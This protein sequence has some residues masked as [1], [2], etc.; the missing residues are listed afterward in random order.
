[1]LARTDAFAARVPALRGATLAVAVLRPD[2]GRVT[3]T[4]CGHPPPLVVSPAGTSRFLPGTGTGPL[5]T[6]SPPLLA[7]TQ[8]QP[9]ELILLYSDGLIERPHR[10]M[11]E[12]LAELATVAAD[13]AANR[14]LP[15][16]SA[17]AAADRVCQ[18]TVELL[19]RT[20][21]TDD[22]TTLAAEWLAVPAPALR[23]QW[24]AELATLRTVRDRFDD[25]LAQVG[26]E[27]EDRDA[28]RLA[29]VELVTNAIEH[30]YRDVPPGPVRLHAALC[31]DGYLECEISDDGTWRT[32]DTAAPY[33]GNGLMV[34]RHMVEQLTV[35]HH[36]GPGGGTVV[37][38]R[39]RLRRPAVLAPVTG[40][41]AAAAGTPEPLVLDL[42]TGGPVPVVTV[43]GAVDATT[44]DQLAQ[45]LLA[46]CRGGTIP[47]TVD[48][49]PVSQLASAGVRALY[50]VQ[51]QLARHQ[52][53]LVLLAPPRSTAHAV[54]ALVGLLPSAA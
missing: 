43:R 32:P 48:L 6:G 36:P 16:G 9:G 12:G 22:V 17:A 5:G 28:L 23:L 47:L 7:S 41:P 35:R 24:T 3:Y 31:D 38:L 42:D 1:M 8:L 46:V 25:W 44:A 27:Q 34:A 52:Q 10:T 18:L 21:Y 20:G 26:P 4:T 19:T 50:Q 30:A 39:H 13:A 51:E 37:A 33:R 45:R 49:G 53:P 11:P 40:G 29:V 15:A 54:L 2:D 14:A